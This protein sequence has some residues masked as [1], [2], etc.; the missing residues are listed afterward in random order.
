MTS[1]ARD[2]YL[3][4][5]INTAT[6]QKLRLILLD[7]AIR[8][9]A[10]TQKHWRE[11]NDEAALESL[12]R[13]RDIVSELIAGIHPAESPLAQ[14]V[15]GLYVY[16]FSALTEAQQTRDEHQLAAVIRVLE[17]DRETWQKV[18]EQLPDRPVPPTASSASREELAPATIAPRQSFSIDA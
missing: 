12:I 16:L 17:Q 10:Q 7:G 5:E 6:P 11:R 9:A 4:T 14:Q 3:E 15:C 13:C 1:S 2:A 18:C 8:R